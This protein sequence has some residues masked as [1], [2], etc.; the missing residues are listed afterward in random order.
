MNQHFFCVTRV[1]T[2]LVAAIT[3]EQ[4]KDG[5]P[6]GK[7]LEVG[8]LHIAATENPVDVKIWCDLMSR[9]SDIAFNA[10]LSKMGIEPKQIT[11]EDIIRRIPGIQ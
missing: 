3:F 7:H 9:L 1:G 2:F 11:T 6:L 8:R 5:E 4:P 10:V